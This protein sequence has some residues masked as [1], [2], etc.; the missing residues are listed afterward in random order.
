MKLTLNTDKTQQLPYTL[1]FNRT[2]S[3][4]YQ[5]G[6]YHSW[7]NY[8]TSVQVKTPLS[9]QPSCRAQGARDDKKEKEDDEKKQNR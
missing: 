9:Y 5:P 3:I 7:Y 6:S 1:I 8:F 4:P 2:K